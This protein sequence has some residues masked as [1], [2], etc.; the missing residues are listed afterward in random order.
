MS[1]GGSRVVVCIFTM[2]VHFVSHLL[3]RGFL[4]SYGEE[5]LGETVLDFLC[6]LFQPFLLPFGRE[7]SGKQRR[8]ERETRRVTEGGR[9]RTRASAAVA[10]RAAR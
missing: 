5:S 7:V 4:T 1:V 6:C 8:R 2:E 9:E 10:P 3:W